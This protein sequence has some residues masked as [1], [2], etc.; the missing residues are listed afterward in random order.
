MMDWI[1]IIKLAD[2]FNK[3][4]EDIAKNYGVDK[5]EVQLLIKQFLS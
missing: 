2:E 3:W 1:Q 4:L 5:D